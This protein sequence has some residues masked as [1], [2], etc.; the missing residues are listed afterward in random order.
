M[1]A[2]FLDSEAAN[3]QQKAYQYL[4]QGDYQKAADIYAQAIERQP[5]NKYYYWHFGLMLL[6]QGQEVEAQ[7][8]WMLAMAEG[9][10]E[11][12]E[13]W[14]AEL[15]QVL[16]AEAI[17]REEIR[18][19]S[20]AWAI[21]QHIRE[22]SPVDINNLLHLILLLIKLERYT[23]EELFELGVI[24]KLQWEE[25]EAVDSELLVQT[26]K[27]LLDYAPLQP[28]SLEFA[29]ASLVHIHSPQAF[30]AVIIPAAVEIA[31]SAR[32]P[33]IASRLAEL[34]LTLT[35]NNPELLRHLSIFYQNAGQYDEGI[36]TAK[37]CYSLLKELP[38]QVFANYL[39]LR[40]LMSAGG[41][42]EEVCSVADRHHSLVELLI[43]EYPTSLHP[44]T[45]QR[46]FSSTFFLPHIQDSPQY[47]KPIQNKVAQL[48]QANIENYAQKHTERYQQG[49]LLRART[50]TT[51][52]P[53]RIGYLSHC[54]K[55]HSVGWL[56]RWLFQHHDRERFKIHGY[57][58]IYK[59]TYDPLQEWYTNHVDRV[60]KCARSGLEIAEQIYQDEIDILIELDSITLD[61]I[62]EVL[63]LKPS[64]IQVTWLGWDSSGLPA[65][66]YF[67]GDPYVLPESAQNYYTEKIWRLPQTYIAV[68][69]FEVGVPTLR[70]EELQIPRDAVIYLSAQR[71]YKRHP[72]TV[73]LQMRI[74]AEVTNS[75][76]LIKGT[77]DEKSIKSFFSKIAEEEGVDCNRLRFLPEVSLEEVHRANLAIAD[78]VLDT[79]PYNGATTTL[80]TLWM[81]IPLVTRV[82]EQFAARNSYGMMINAGITEGIAWSDDEYLE[83]GVR[84]GK[85]T[86]LRQQVA[87]KLRQSKQTS[88][89]WN[90]KQFTRDVENAY[91]QMWQKYIESRS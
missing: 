82:G 11:Q 50:R 51:P 21:R 24:E 19:Y 34:G 80:E 25:L 83:W 39:I 30:I 72:E 60:C 43:K 8:A 42:W 70:R 12:V 53:L 62:C 68:D 91:E 28:S 74:I 46:L 26:L 75:Y 88:P 63:A 27:S 4:L 38:E 45:V 5:T 90:A 13:L 84:L 36:R 47:T 59:S 15:I 49:H 23:G 55:R 77:A 71:G 20:T 32:Q 29:E 69:G 31:A 85:D 61:T 81:G 78:I 66:D 14:T 54:L 57:F 18:D 79:Y 16:Q 56:A 41:Y 1:N 73:R 52:K 6:L 17:R 58:L 65:I 86:A 33:Q 9:E 89:L 48:C 76:F 3:L 35:P 40:G 37:L 2:R 64:P 10:T 44:V 67:L 7:T 87:W 22:I